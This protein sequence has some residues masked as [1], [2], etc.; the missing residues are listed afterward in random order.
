MVRRREFIG[1]IGC[2]AVATTFL[3]TLRAQGASSQKVG[4]LSVRSAADSAADAAAFVT[5]LQE[6]GFTD[7]RNVSIE[8]RWG[9]GSYEKLKA[10]AEELVRLPA[11]VI[12]GF[13]PS[14]AL[15]AKQLTT[16]IPIV[17][18]SS[19]DPVKLGL[20]QS[21]SKPGGNV[22]GVSYQAV[23]LNAKRMEI[24]SE[25]TPRASL[26]GTFVNP[27]YP[28]ADD[29]LAD[30]KDVTTR[31]GRTLH[32]ETVRSEAVIDAAFATL[33]SA[34]VSSLI[35]NGDAFFNRMRK[36]IIALA[37]R[38]AMPTIYPWSEYAVDGGLIS[39]GPNLRDGF[40][41][42]GTYAGKILKGA[43]PADLPVLQ[44]V[45]FDLV[46]NAKTAKALGI[47]FPPTLL[48]RASDVIE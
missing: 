38:H 39:Y 34:G 19:A 22:T 14:P 20:V 25:L 4:F 13:G 21:L 9:E 28:N 29:E 42:V 17:F 35:V 7:G 44:P 5:G 46:V 41:Q 43:H 26:I 30:L 36:T 37:A 12:A 33:K 2:A 32:V 47:E 3:H 27:D 18:T 8:F 15:A 10:Q 11:A 48:A 31:I 24:L 6:E 16:T 45:K 40:R 23:E 1:R